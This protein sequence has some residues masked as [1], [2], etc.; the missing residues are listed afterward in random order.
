L[1][2]SDGD[3]SQTGFSGAESLSH[4]FVFAFN[5]ARTFSSGG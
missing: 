1:P 4:P 5:N 2:S 3:L